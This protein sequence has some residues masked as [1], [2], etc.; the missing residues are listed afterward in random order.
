MCSCKEMARNSACLKLAGY[1]EAE[2]QGNL[3][4]WMRQHNGGQSLDPAGSSR[5]EPAKH[6]SGLG[7][8][9][10][11]DL[12]KMASNQQNGLLS[13]AIPP[14]PPTHPLISPP[15]PW[16]FCNLRQTLVRYGDGRYGKLEYVRG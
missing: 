15:I 2:Q 11:Q 7:S 8:S 3:N 13:G 1:L 5:D 6:T 9:F 10:S 4:E 16:E 14:H 12:N